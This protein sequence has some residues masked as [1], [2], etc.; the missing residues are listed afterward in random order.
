MHCDQNQSIPGNLIQYWY[1]IWYSVF[2]FI[3]KHQWINKLQL[4]M[5]LLVITNRLQLNIFSITKWYVEDNIHS[6]AV[7]EYLIFSFLF[8]GQQSYWNQCECN[9]IKGRMAL[10]KAVCLYMLHSL[11][12]VPPKWF[13][14]VW[15][16][17]GICCFS[18][19]S[20]S[21]SWGE[22]W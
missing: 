20:F 14:L 11:G 1:C 3:L 7:Q 10:H 6:V 13:W 15:I 18:V 8:K 12:S 2:F 16:C 22:S 17:T 21:S 9:A 5:K 19:A 4:I